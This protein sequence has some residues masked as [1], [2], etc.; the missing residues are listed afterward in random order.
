MRLQ[1]TG[2]QLE[3]TDALK[4][5]AETHLKKLEHF[6]THIDQVHIVFEVHK[7]LHHVKATAH[8]P[9][10]TLV[11]DHESENMYQGIEKVVQKLYRQIEKHKQ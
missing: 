11:A 6:D 4:E 3:L 5:Y 1:I 9:G 7:H 10:H 8:I 2:H